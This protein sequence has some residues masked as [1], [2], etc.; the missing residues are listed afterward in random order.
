MIVV[1]SLVDKPNNLGGLCR[2]CEIFGVEELV[3][4]DLIFASDPGFQALSMSSEKKQKIEAVRPDDLPEYLEGMRRKGYTV[5]AAEQ[6]TDSVFL[7][8]FMFP[9]KR[10]FTCCWT[11]NLTIEIIRQAL[12]LI[13]TP[14]SASSHHCDE[15]EHP[16][17]WLLVKSL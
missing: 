2:T 13:L 6:T 4:A 14:N 17:V 12:P 1:A 11:T 16:E 10:E 9:K 7:H 5:I 3:V 15:L 8:K